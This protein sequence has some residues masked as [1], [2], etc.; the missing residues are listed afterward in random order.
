MSL[1]YYYDSN[2]D[3]IGFEYN[4]QKYLYLKN[5]QNDIIGILDSNGNIVVQYYY[6]GYGNLVSIV[7]TSSVNLGSIN[8]FRYR[9][10]YLDIETGWYYLNSR[11]Y[12]PLI[13]RFITPDDISY[14]GASGTALSYNLY[15]YCENNPIVLVDYEGNDAKLILDFDDEGLI[16]VGHMALIVQDYGGKWHLIEFTGSSK[17]NAKVYIESGEGR[18]GKKQGFW[19]SILSI[20]GLGGWRT[21]YIKGDF[22]K[23]LEYARKYENTDYGGYNLIF[24]NCLH[25]VRNALRQGKSKNSLLQL[26]FMFSSTIVPR[27]FFNNALI[28]S[29]MRATFL[30]KNRLIGGYYA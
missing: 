13:K 1:F 7:D 5:L 15:S 26:Y 2:N 29:S 22:T 28:V 3:I 17:K 23:S 18:F 14:L 21:L 25:F 30:N 11:F 6:E 10:Y 12:D 8:S 20:V 27:V 4:N 9:S 16:V 19:K 24:N